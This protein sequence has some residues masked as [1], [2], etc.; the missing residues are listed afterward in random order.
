MDKTKFHERLRTLRKKN[1]LTQA[2]VAQHLGYGATAIS[3]YETGNNEPCITDLIKLSKLFHVSLD[4]L[5]CST[6]VNVLIN[7]EKEYTED[8]IELLQHTLKLYNDQRRLLISNAEW[9]AHQ[10][11]LAMEQQPEPAEHTYQKRPSKIAQTPVPFDFED[12]EE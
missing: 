2:E 8:V 5:L 11:R 6:D 9:L 12:T 4:Y 3:N 7:E 1:R 10:Q